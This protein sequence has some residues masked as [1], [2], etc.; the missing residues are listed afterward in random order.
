M[1]TFDFKNGFSIGHGLVIAVIS[2][3]LVQTILTIS[4]IIS[5]MRKRVPTNDKLLWILIVLLASTI[6]AIIYFAYGSGK[7]DD[8]EAEIENERMSR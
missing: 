4:A 6:G 2:L 1:M 5:I 7:L 8:K 3:A